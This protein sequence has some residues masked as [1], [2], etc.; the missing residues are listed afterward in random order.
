MGCLFGFLWK[1]RF[2]H[3]SR[4]G[5]VAHQLSNRSLLFSWKLWVS[6]SLSQ[7]CKSSGSYWISYV[8][9][10]IKQQNPTISS[11]FTQPWLNR[12]DFDQTLSW[13]SEGCW[14]QKPNCRGECS[15]ENRWCRA[16]NSFS[17]AKKG[18]KETGSNSRE[19]HRWTRLL[20]TLWLFEIAME[21][22]HF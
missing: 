18:M 9:L 2:Y 4:T 21:N 3:G 8:W 7:V 15:R 5:D 16:K 10:V 1:H 11:F 20:H 22:H 6:L 13:R 12:P 14:R 19:K 17:W